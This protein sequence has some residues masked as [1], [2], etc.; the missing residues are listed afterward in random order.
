MMGPP[1][2][3]L[4]CELASEAHQD[5]LCALMERASNGCF[6]RWWHFDRE[7]IYWTER[8]NVYP[9]KNRAELVAA[10]ARGDDEAQGIVA[11]VGDVVVGWLKLTPAPKLAKLFTRRVY[12]TLDCFDGERGR[13]WLIGCFV[14]APAHR[15]RGV[16]RALVAAA[17]DAA[18][19]AGA[20]ALEAFPRRPKQ[21][22]ADAEMW[23]GVASVFLDAG[24]EEIAGPEPY[25]VL[26]LVL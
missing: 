1:T 7:D 14:I 16:S 13:V 3:P 18:R 4:R 17:I 9:Q 2:A 10:L 26:R 15:R 12:R 20:A 8:C 23:M 22:T 24:F 21:Q 19:G 6:C 11:M 25:P 5:G